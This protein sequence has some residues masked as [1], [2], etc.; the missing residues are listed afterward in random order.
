MPQRRPWLRRLGFLTLIALGLVGAAAIV[1]RFTGD[2]LTLGP[3]VAVVEV[4]GVISDA[5]P[6]CDTLASL[7]KDARVG[8]V[9]VR[10]E[11]PGG[12]VAPS[13]EIYEEIERLRATKPVIA[14]LGNVAAS[15]GYYVAAA[16]NTIVAAAGTLTGS[17]GVIMEFRQLEQLAQKVGVGEDIVKSGPYKDIGHPLRPMTEAERKLLQGMVNDVYEQFVDAVARGRGMAPERVRELADG[18]LYS[19]QQ[20]K[21]AGLVDELGGLNTAV[22]LAWTRA[23]GTGEPSVRRVKGPW[24]PWWLDLVG[25]LARPSPAGLGGGLLF[26]YGGPTPQ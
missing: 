10:I 18:R 14:S 3:V 22:R 26:L 5:E 13:Q 19:G 23:G 15:G 20:A 25:S 21:E 11:S 8:A 24:R 6:I 2:G 12:G 17:I 7:A 16:T 1:E 4:Q 9:V